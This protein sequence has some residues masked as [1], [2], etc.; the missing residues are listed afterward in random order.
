MAALL[1][2]AC[3]SYH[4]AVRPIA[5]ASPASRRVASIVGCDREP[6]QLGGGM[7]PP[8]GDEGE[9]EAYL[10]ALAEARLASAKLQDAELR[11]RQAAERRPAA[12]AVAA[13][14][15]AALATKPVGARTSIS[16]SDAGTL[17]V[18]VPPAGFNAA[19][20]LM[21][22]AFTAA[23]FS[24]I[25]P[26]TGTMIA[27]GGAS[28]L[29]MLPFWLAG[30]VVAKQTVVDPVKATSLSIGEFAWELQQRAV[31]LP[32]SS[33]AGAS[34]E[35]DGCSVEVAAYVNDVPQHVLRLFS[36]TQTWSIGDGLTVVELEYIAG[37][38]NA[39]LATLKR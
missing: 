10:S 37:E 28:A 9:E 38:V 16:R 1:A 32:L 13:P 35:L 14:A 22:G 20:T 27:T 5:P 24:A 18:E 6:G 11:L 33:A 15:V 21:G 31:G 29:F 2:I 19:G 39:H 26:A 3:S 7:P 30:G 23:W 17:L 34:D 4:L 8:A 25:V 36:G 12:P